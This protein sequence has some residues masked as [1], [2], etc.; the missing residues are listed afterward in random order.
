MLGLNPQ[1]G[2]PLS[3][4]VVRVPN[5]SSSYSNNQEKFVLQLIGAVLFK[6]Q[7]DHDHFEFPKFLLF[8][9]KIVCFIF[10]FSS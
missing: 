5:L 8:L 4:I 1:I 9:N 10:S 3:R 2:R 7:N 6:N